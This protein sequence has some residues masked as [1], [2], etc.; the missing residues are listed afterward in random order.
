[1]SLPDNF[2]RLSGTKKIKIN[3]DENISKIIC[4]KVISFNTVLLL[5]FL[6]NVLKGLISIFH[7][8]QFLVYLLL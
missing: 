1:V 6:N 7:L 5:L 3:L 8:A 2:V 4:Y